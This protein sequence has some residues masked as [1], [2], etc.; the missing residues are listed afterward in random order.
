MR[1]VAMTAWKI[2]LWVMQTTACD[3]AGTAR[4][5]HP[6][7]PSKKS[8]HFHD[9]MPAES[10]ALFQTNQDLQTISCNLGLRKISRQISLQSHIALLAVGGLYASPSSGI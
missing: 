6:V 8:N 10:V 4:K 1:A 3:L 7:L 2:H 9:D 5:P